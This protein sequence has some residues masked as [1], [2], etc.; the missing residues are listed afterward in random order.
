MSS[1]L[2]VQLR[3]WF[4]VLRLGIIWCMFCCLRRYGL[5][6]LIVAMRA[7]LRCLGEW[8][9]AWS[10]LTAGIFQ[11]RYAQP[12]RSASRLCVTMDE[13]DAAVE[14]LKWARQSF[15]EA[16]SADG[17]SNASY[18]SED[19]REEETPELAVNDLVSAFNA[20]DVDQE[21]GTRAKVH[22]LEERL[23]IATDRAERWRKQ[24]EMLDKSGGNDPIRRASDVERY[25]AQIRVMRKELWDAR[26][27]TEEWKLKE[28]GARAEVATLRATNSRL[29]SRLKDAEKLQKI[30]AVDSPDP[31]AEQVEELKIALEVAQRELNRTEDELSDLRVAEIRSSGETR[32]WQEKFRALRSEKAILE[33][34]LKSKP[35]AGSYGSN[36]TDGNDESNLDSSDRSVGVTTFTRPQRHGRGDSTDEDDG[37]SSSSDGDGS[38]PRSPVETTMKSIPEQVAMR[39]RQA[40]QLNEELQERMFEAEAEVQRYQQLLENRKYEVTAREKTALDENERLKMEVDAVRKELQEEQGALIAANADFEEMKALHA[41][42]VAELKQEHAAVAMTLA[43]L[44]KDQ[45]EVARLKKKQEQAQQDEKAAKAK[46]IEERRRQQ[47]DAE[48]MEKE[49]VAEQKV[50]EEERQ[51]ETAKRVQA[52]HTVQ[53]QDM[54]RKKEEELEAFLVKETKILEEEQKAENEAHRVANALLS[55][56]QGQLVSMET[57]AEVIQRRN[58]NMLELSVKEERQLALELVE[59]EREKA[60]AAIKE[61]LEDQKRAIE[62]KYHVTEERVERMQVDERSLLTRLK[63]D[64]ADIISGIDDEIA[65]TKTVHEAALNAAADLAKKQEQE[66]EQQAFRQEREAE[67]M[68]YKEKQKIRKMED[69]LDDLMRKAKRESSEAIKTELQEN[70][71]KVKEATLALTEMEVKVK[72]DKDRMEKEHAQ[73]IEDQDQK[74]RRKKEEFLKNMKRLQHTL[75]E[76]KRENERKVRRA[77]AALKAKETA[78]RNELKKSKQDHDDMLRR[79]KREYGEAMEKAKKAHE[80]NLEKSQ[81]ALKGASKT[82]HLLQKSMQRKRTNVSKLGMAWKSKAKASA[83]ANEHRAALNLAMREKEKEAARKEAEQ[84]KALAKIEQEHKEL[85]EQQKKSHSHA[86]DTALKENEDKLR[87]AEEL[88]SAAHRKHQSILQEQAASLRAQHEADLQEKDNE[89]KEAARKLKEEHEL[90]LRRQEEQIA[91]K[92]RKQQEDAERFNAAEKKAWLAKQEALVREQEKKDAER[93][94]LLE[95]AKQE[96]IALLAQQKATH[97]NRFDEALRKNEEKVKSYE[98]RHE[99]KH[100]EHQAEIKRMKEEHEKYLR[101]KHADQERALAQTKLENEK[102][103]ERSIKEYKIKMKF[104]SRMEEAADR[105]SSIISRLGSKWKGITA[106]RKEVKGVEQQAIEEVKRVEA[107]RKQVEQE[108][109]KREEDLRAEIQREREKMEQVMKEEEEKRL[110]LERTLEVDKQKMIELRKKEK[111]QV[112]FGNV[113]GKWKNRA[114]DRK[115]KSD[116][117]RERKLAD[118]K[119]KKEE[120]DRKEL[121]KKLHE[122]EMSMADKEKEMAKKDAELKAIA[123][124]KDEQAQLMKQI[125][126]EREEAQKEFERE[127]EISKRRFAEEQEEVRA[128]MRKEQEEAQAKLRSFQDQQ[129]RAQEELDQKEKLLLEARE[130]QS[131]LEEEAKRKEKA[132][133]EQKQVLA[134]EQRNAQDA[135]LAHQKDLARKLELQQIKMKEMEKR[136]LANEHNRTLLEAEKH[137]E[138]MLKEALEGAAKKTANLLEQERVRAKELIKKEQE[139]KE[140]LLAKERAITAEIIEKEKAAAMALIEKEKHES[141][142]RIEEEQT[143][144]AKILQD[145]QA[146]AAAEL[147]KQREAAA[148]VRLKAR[149]DAAKAKEDLIKQKMGGLLGNKMQAIAG[150]KNRLVMKFAQKWKKKSDLHS[151]VG[152]VEKVLEKERAAQNEFLLANMKLKTQHAKLAAEMEETTAKLAEREKILSEREEELRVAKESHQSEIEALARQHEE[153][154]RESVENCEKLMNELRKECESKVEGSKEGHESALRKFQKRSEE[155]QAAVVD[156]ENRMVEMEKETKDILTKMVEKVESKNDQLHRARIRVAKLEAERNL[157]RKKLHDFRTREAGLAEEAATEAERQVSALTSL[158][159]QVEKDAMELDM[160]RGVDPELMMSNGRLN[161]NN[162]YEQSTYA[163]PRGDA[164]LTRFSPE[165]VS[166]SEEADANSVYSRRNTPVSRGPSRKVSRSNSPANFVEQTNLG[167]VSPSAAVEH[168]RDGLLAYESKQQSDIAHS[169]EA[170]RHLDYSRLAYLDRLQAQVQAARAEVDSAKEAIRI[171][172]MQKSY[173][174]DPTSPS[175]LSIGERLLQ[176]RMEVPLLGPRFAADYDEALH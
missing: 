64:N 118:E 129:K 109:R 162:Q 26:K 140:L 127:R 119:L 47:L 88:V 38:A 150:K 147:E 138:R 121:E 84:Q 61:H 68:L 45:K 40:A 37:S 14:S 58:E 1:C 171:R 3:F 42:E 105:K 74:V 111:G 30:V 9:H 117:E 169:H 33:K 70:Q 165:F 20:T 21:A 134:E 8:V 135:M 137:E 164:D 59:I 15:L 154:V 78:Y 2:V 124:K 63:E 87:R 116:M 120:D 69:N 62:E 156:A 113:L 148:E 99:E 50:E 51:I 19:E 23:K 48:I 159:E 143:L 52:E 161:H 96:H 57:D 104:I 65:M 173:F 158:R 86:Y 94:R 82:I 132:M 35:K 73:A 31:M 110:E 102:A 166:Y 32:E 29:K 114:A 4:S 71:Q 141:R 5:S 10:R 67:E 83:S 149:N 41:T 81:Q 28:A 18:S 106:K 43:V 160:H 80:L 55:D 168:I 152:K 60:Q 92:I 39:L 130:K 98:R 126:K 146:K 107:H 144:A 112:S 163:F 100:A 175:R 89:A 123:A 157:L 128:K 6:S 44:S 25:Q 7:C 11:P 131:R 90:E 85:V 24:A 53:M 167:F 122:Q 142:Q 75:D 93:E 101:Q 16:S 13:I 170:A 22:E 46:L 155:W 49:R 125:T 77:E 79:S 108:M 36:G 66:W 97:S 133:E 136:D 76:T 72:A 91:A 139:E 27:Q 17:S 103:V 56:A 12:E 153:N 151:A 176:H 54:L 172:E 145:E 34:R 174:V 95:K 115:Q